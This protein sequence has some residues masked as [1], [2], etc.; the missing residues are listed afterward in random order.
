[1]PEANAASGAG[2]L[3]ERLP[4]LWAGASLGERRTLLLTMLESVYVD[5]K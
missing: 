3:I 2:R 5:T 4:E 1:V